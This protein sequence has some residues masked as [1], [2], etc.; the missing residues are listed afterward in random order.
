MDYLI[1]RNKQNKQLR[2]EYMQYN[3]MYVIFLKKAKF[4]M[5][6]EMYFSKI[7]K[8]RKRLTKIQNFRRW[9]LLG[10][11]EGAGSW[12]SH[13]RVSTVLIMLYHFAYRKMGLIQSSDYTC[14]SYM[15]FMYC[16]FLYELSTNLRY[17]YGLL[18]L[19]L[20]L[21][22]LLI[23]CLINKKI[24]FSVKTPPFLQIFPNIGF[25]FYT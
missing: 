24:I 17:K 15:H 4:F 6:M 1:S 9:C 3:F 2:E 8:R 5:F 20:K 14:N 25:F 18:A 13:R 7:R 11:K 23:T 12:E 19:T 22:T 10:S 21:I 16:T